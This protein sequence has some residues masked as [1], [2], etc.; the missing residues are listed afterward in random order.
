MEKTKQQQLSQLKSSQLSQI[1]MQDEVCRLRMIIEEGESVYKQDL[2]V[3]CKQVFE[4]EDALKQAN[5][6]LLLCQDEFSKEMSSLS[7]THKLQISF[8]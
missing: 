8:L 5:A 7:Q 6:Q 3:K 1:T 4:L 2:A